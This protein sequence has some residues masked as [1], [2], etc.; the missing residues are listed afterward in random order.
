MN[1]PFDKLELSSPPLCYFFRIAALQEVVEAATAKGYRC[2]SQALGDP[3]CGDAFYLG[4][5]QYFV[6]HGV[7]PHLDVRNLSGQHLLSY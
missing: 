4:Q 3:C 5:D 2:K 1:L 7:R 6:N